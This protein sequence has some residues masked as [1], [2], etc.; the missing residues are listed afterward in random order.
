MKAR[1]NRPKALPSKSSLYAACMAIH[2][3]FYINLGPF[4]KPSL[5]AKF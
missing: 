3:R 5:Q 4:T 2:N 1:R